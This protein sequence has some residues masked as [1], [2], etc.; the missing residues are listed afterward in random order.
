VIPVDSDVDTGLVG[1]ALTDGV[2]DTGG[3]L[4]ICLSGVDGSP[5]FARFRFGRERLGRLPGR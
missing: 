1:A 4:T 2:L 5:R 3:R